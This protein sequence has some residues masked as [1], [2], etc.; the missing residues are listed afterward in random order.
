MAEAGPSTTKRKA[1]SRSQHSCTVCS[2][3]FSRAEYVRRHFISKHAGA[4]LECALCEATFSRHDLLVRHVRIFHAGSEAPGRPPPPD[5]ELPAPVPVSASSTS[6]AVQSS[7]ESGGSAQIVEADDEFERSP[8]SIRDEASPKHPRLASPPVPSNINSL[9]PPPVKPPLAPPAAFEPLPVE[10]SD[11]SFADFL[12]HLSPEGPPFDLLQV[13]QEP[14]AVIPR[15]VEPL[16]AAVARPLN[17]AVQALPGTEEEWKEEGGTEL[18]RIIDLIQRRPKEPSMYPEHLIRSEGGGQGRFFMGSQRFCIA[19]LYPWEIPPLPRLSRFAKQA[20]TS[21]L[22]VI[23]LA[24]HPTLSLGEIAPP[25]AFALSVCGAGFFQ[26]YSGFY[27]EL[28]HVKRDFAAEHLAEVIVHEQERMP[29]VQTLLLYQ[30]VGAFGNSYEERNFTRKHHPHLIQALLDVIPPTAQ[31]PQDL[32]LPAND[33]DRAWKSWVEKELYVRV[34]FLCY[35]AD[36]QTG[37]TFGDAERLLSHSH[38]VLADLP[39]P[40]SETLWNASSASE[41]RS[42][43]ERDGRSS[44]TFKE[45]LNAL[46]VKTPP[47]H[48]SPAARILS[49]LSKLSPLAITVLFQTLTSL[50]SQ[51]T[52]S[53]RLLRNSFAF[54]SSS[55]TGGLDVVG[56]EQS[57]PAPQPDLLAAAAA[58][59]SESMDRIVFGVKVLRLLGGAAATNGWFRG[60][61]PIFA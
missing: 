2:K 9:P 48:T 61:E 24:H 7:P 5:L 22:P 20:C 58:S 21:L 40:A 15:A 29:R 3:V 53:Q 33:L 13:E 25:F 39:L 28:S 46:L 49:S 51:I 11:Q 16:P 17:W 55:T 30:L 8:P 23:P 37:S 44:V 18:E 4:S 43:V 42:L 36:I 38:P 45:A 47:K 26:S 35:L 54:P 10:T 34:A 50:Q 31:V 57:I 12:A 41:W 59:A 6:Q 60:V 1:P 32:D 14:L 56:A 27:Q 19:Y 52:N